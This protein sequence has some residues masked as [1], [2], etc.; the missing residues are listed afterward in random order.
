MSAV[1]SHTINHDSQQRKF[2]FYHEYEEM[3]F[4]KPS[5]GGLSCR[6]VL[7]NNATVLIKGFLKTT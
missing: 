5:D 4:D 3:E 7:E 6:L 2:L 1:V